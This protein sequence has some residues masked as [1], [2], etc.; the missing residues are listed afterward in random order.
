MQTSTTNRF[1]GA[2]ALT[3]WLAVLLPHAPALAQ[4]HTMAIPKA[5]KGKIITSNQEVDVPAAGANFQA[6][7]NKQ[8][9]RTFTKDEEGKWVIHFIAFFDKPLPGEAMGIVVL[10]EKNE[11][12]ASAEVGGQKGQTTLASHIVVDSTEFPGKEHTLKIYFPKGGK[13]IPLATKKILL[14]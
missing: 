13:P 8:D 2:I 3:T 10:D 12:A 4:T 6:K 9:R 5:L 11:P 7:L 1:L 14:K